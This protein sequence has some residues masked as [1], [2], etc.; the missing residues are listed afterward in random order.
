MSGVDSCPNDRFARTYCSS[1]ELFLKS[2]D[3]D[4]NEQSPRRWAVFFNNIQ[5]QCLFQGKCYNKGA[6]LLDIIVRQ[7]YREVSTREGTTF[8]N[9]GFDIFGNQTQSRNAFR[10][11]S[12]NNIAKFHYHHINGE[13]TLD[14]YSDIFTSFA[15]HTG[16]SHEIEMVAQCLQT[17]L[18]N[19]I[20]AV[21]F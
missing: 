9:F 20:A 21:S 11:I 17:D 10:V 19:M 6:R 13:R 2:I 8:K 12:H 15:E 5:Y 3:G 4:T 14:E 16:S 1:L 18:C 7:V